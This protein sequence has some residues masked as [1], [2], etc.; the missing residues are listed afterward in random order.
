[1][2]DLPLDIVVLAKSVGKRQKRE[3]NL[4]SNSWLSKARRNFMMGLPNNEVL[5]YC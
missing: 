4:F 2:A 1:M 3:R 5:N